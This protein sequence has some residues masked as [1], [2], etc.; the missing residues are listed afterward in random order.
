MRAISSAGHPCMVDRVTPP[1]IRAGTSAEAASGKTAATRRAATRPMSARAFTLRSRK[2]CMFGWRTPC[3]VVADADVEQ[4]A[5]KVTREVQVAV[6]GV[7]QHPGS[8]IL[9]EG[10]V[11]GQLLR[12]LDVVA[13]VLHVDARLCD[14]RSGRGSGPSSAR[15]RGPRTANAETMLAASCE[16]GPAATPI[17]VSRLRSRQR[18]VNGS[19]TAGG[20]RARSGCP[21]SNPGR[22]AHRRSRRRVVR[23]TG[24]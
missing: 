8:K 20:R 13:L 17:G 22:S 14:A 9:V 19:V 12:P 6:E 3:E 1:A 15:S 23:W 2:R 7:D 18:R 24:D 21:G 5:G 4:H 16:W 10:L 11:E